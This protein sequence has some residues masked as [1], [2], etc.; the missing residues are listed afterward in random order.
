MFYFVK[1]NTSHKVSKN[2]VGS[3]DGG[4][5]SHV[6]E[7]NLTYLVI[8]KSNKVHVT[9]AFVKLKHYL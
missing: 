4:V 6:V 9:A 8:V 5:Y 1:N 2:G 7:T 3:A